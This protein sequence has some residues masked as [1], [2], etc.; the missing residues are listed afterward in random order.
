M[1]QHT[2]IIV[3][4]AAGAGSTNR[5][6][7]EIRSLLKNS[8]LSFEYQLTE[9]KGHAI[10]LARAAAGDGYRYLIAVGGDG[11]IHEVA[12]G[13]MQSAGSGKTALGMVCTGTGSDLSRSVGIPHDHRQACLSLAQGRHRKI[14][15]GLVEYRRNGATRKRY[16][17]NS[18]GIGFDAAVVAAT[19][20]LP[21]YFGGTVPYLFGLLRTLLTY[22][23]K[24]VVFSIGTKTPETAKVLGIVVANGR[25]F[26]GGMQVAPHAVVDD[27]LFD[28]III[29]NLGKAEVLRVFPRIYKGTHIGYPKIRLERDRGITIESAQPFLLQADGELLGEGPVRFSILP[30]A[31]DLVI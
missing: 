18:A 10:E 14:D 5:K 16:F 3:N 27:G 26:G 9:E 29:G 11:T 13:I 20:K 8:G 12:N 25:Y 28:V 1:K 19:D 6:W 7:P 30:Q 21:K 24:R 4:P 23:S 31:L 15:V 22:R 17:L 2:K